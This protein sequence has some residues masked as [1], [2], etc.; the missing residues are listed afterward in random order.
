M[1][2]PAFQALERFLKANG[3][4]EA[5][6]YIDLL[7]DLSDEAGFPVEVYSGPVQNGQSREILD[8]NEVEIY[9]FK[10]TTSR[11]LALLPGT[12]LVYGA[13]DSGK[14][15]LIEGMAFAIGGA[16]AVESQNED[17]M[18]VGATVTRS[19]VKA[20]GALIKR[21]LDKSAKTRGP[22]AGD[23][24]I[25]QSLNVEI[26]GSK[27]G[28]TR[29]AQAL[30]DDWLGVPWQFIRRA[31]L[32]G[33]GELASILDEAPARRRNMFFQMLGLEG[34]ERTREALAN[35][36]R[37]KEGAV[38]AQ[39]GTVDE[40]TARLTKAKASREP[41]RLEQL[42]QEYRT[43]E[44][45]GA[46]S[47]ALIKAKVEQLEAIRNQ[48]RDYEIGISRRASFL[49]E[50]GRLQQ[51][52][53]LAV[54][55]KDVTV[56]LE[57]LRR[58]AASKRDDLSKIEAAMKEIGDRGNRIKALP[59]VCPTC[60]ELGWQC[61]SNDTV[62]QQKLAELRSD[63]SKLNV[64]ATEIKAALQK[65]DFEINQLAKQNTENQ[66]LAQEKARILATISG[67]EKVVAL[68]PQVDPGRADLLTTNAT[69]LVGEIQT[70]KQQQ[71]A[72]TAA[73][74]ADVHRQIGE[75]QKLDSEIAWL[76]GELQKLD[77]AIDRGYVDRIR[78]LVDFFS[79]GALPLW[80][81][82]EHVKTINN[83]ALELATGDRYQYRFNDDL[84][85]EIID[86]D[87]KAKVP[88]S[89]ASGSSRQR[90]ALILRATLGR[91]LQEL[92]GVKIPLFWI[93]EIP[94]QDDQNSSMIIDVV[95]RLT[96]W[97]PKV[98]LAASQWERYIG[99]FD[100]EFK[101][102]PQ[103]EIKTLQELNG[104][105]ADAKESTEKKA[106]RRR[107]TKAES[108]SAFDQLA[109]PIKEAIS[110][111]VEGGILDDSEA[112]PF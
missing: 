81:T 11:T 66:A 73:R 90:G 15:S 91:Y 106:P 29:Q 1:S 23:V 78:N 61:G 8:L 34:C 62:K 101:V 84:E 44:A 100:H 56:N 35:V 67:K 37:K 109:N 40:L 16:T 64:S 27:E 38:S 76:T 69:L 102:G 7:T 77:G 103:D 4:P 58:N 74:R 39:A 51:S 5:Q 60:L 104:A 26:G 32:V 54:E 110:E 30:I 3:V 92:G 65:L 31:M 88:P 57:G 10:G 52:P 98:V 28:R 99:A 71:P 79:K 85:V 49:D 17:V 48:L 107:T 75:A 112:P 22:N 70:L 42:Q 108:E 83:R 95:K 41:Y 59:P 12:T 36:L 45:T 47:E 46:S 53:A 25:D 89:M 80:L 19:T 9:N 24:T 105:L 33:Q 82:K 63:W 55:I 14:S 97:Y 2:T 21:M 87:S 93:D 94:F 20:T 72:E 111:A 86:S 50:I 6:P 96:Q 68:L 13:N 43:L 18:R